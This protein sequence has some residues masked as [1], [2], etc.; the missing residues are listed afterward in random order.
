[1]GMPNRDGH[2]AIDER[3]ARQTG[4]AAVGSDTIRDQATVT[5]KGAASAESSAEALP[6]GD[7]A[8]ARDLGSA[9]AERFRIL[10]PHARGG[11]GQ[12]FVARDEQLGR[13]VALKEIQGGLADDAASRNRFLLEAEVTGNLE[14]P[15]FVPVYALGRYQDGRP[16]YA[17]RLIRGES[18]KEAITGLHADGRRSSLGV[19]NRAVRPLVTRLVDVC[20][21]M[22]YAHSRGVIH[23]DLK[24]ANILLGPYGETVVVDWGLAKVLTRRE[25][26]GAA[27]GASEPSVEDT[28]SLSRQTTLNEA[29]ASTL[30]SVEEMTRGE[31]LSD[32]TATDSGT[33]SSS[34][35]STRHDAEPMATPPSSDVS[36]WLPQ[37]GSSEGHTLPGRAVGTPAY[38]SPEQAAGALERLGPASD[39][40]SLGA[41][42]YCILT[43]RPPF[44]E[45]G[46][47]PTVLG[48]VQSG[49]FTPPREIAPAMSKP[50][51]AICLKAMARDPGDRYPTM[52]A[53]AEDLESYLADEPVAA[54]REGLPSRLARWTR[55]HKSWALALG[56]AM[57]VTLSVVGIA[58]EGFRRT[59]GRERM[60]REDGLRIAA[61]FAARTVAAEIDR[62]WRILE[63]EV[64]DPSFLALMRRAPALP[65][66]SPERI[67][68]QQWIE[69]H[70]NAHQRSAS[71]ANWFITDTA[72]IQ[73]ARAPLVARSIGV[74]YAF[75]DY[76]SG[77]GRDLPEGSR[78]APTGHPHRSIVFHSRNTGRAIVVFS[79]PI[80][81]VLADAA[82]A[83][84]EEGPI[85]GVIGMAVDVGRF[86]V[87][88][89][90]V[91]DDQVAVLADLRPDDSNR[92]GLILH[93]PGLELTDTQQRMAYLS[94]QRLRLLDDLRQSALSRY[95]AKTSS[96]VGSAG[97]G[98]AHLPNSFARDYHDPVGGAYSGE[99]LAAFEPV[100]IEGRPDLIDDTGWLVIVQERAGEAAK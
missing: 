29:A 58:A 75:R 18:L 96:T 1:M 20:N 2:G 12:I 16:Y 100:V 44:G 40:Y 27:A 68:L 42:L 76:F 88:Q 53:L 72:G 86:A 71:A 62:R 21:A 14:H 95:R 38:M 79:M 37:S 31:A 17:M 84:S 55:R 81:D 59:A 28:L 6:V 7:V 56:A 54:Y 51:E 50:L 69:T 60:A 24:P 98:S 9:S 10:R 35:A 43:G 11:L 87:L 93:H 78:P 64:D 66:N 70:F 19:D 3:S 26:Q 77:L 97:R 49:R 33:A 65:A 91:G 94:P 48:Q 13:E 82:Q 61:K 46:D 22:A 8:V 39:V 30:A 83:D 52:D 5:H 34:S 4:S 67:A 85:L 32:V 45:S 15:G 80:R 57:L 99:W 41:T 74:N 73:I 89:L 25:S 47:V 90:D 23:R 92:Q 36:A 63:D